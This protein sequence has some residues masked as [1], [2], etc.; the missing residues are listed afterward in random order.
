MALVNGINYAWVNITL[1]LFGV[2]VK[3]ITK[4]S[5]KKKKEKTNNYGAGGEP[6]SRGIGRSEYEASI[7][8]YRDEWQ[9]IINVSPT[10]DPLDIPAF[11]IPIVFG[12][13]RV[14]AQTD[15]LQS[16]EFLEDAFDVS[17]GDTSIKITVPIIIAGIQ[18]L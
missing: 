5:Y 17:E 6:V 14:T 1:V 9:R 16:C 10:K 12:G 11:D 15:I 8:L 3:G 7:E 2:P 13:S 4:I 18:H